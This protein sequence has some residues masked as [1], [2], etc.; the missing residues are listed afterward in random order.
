[1]LSHELLRRQPTNPAQPSYAEPDNNPHIKQRN[2][3]GRQAQQWSQQNK[4]GSAHGQPDTSMP[5][6]DHS[7]DMQAQPQIQSTF[8]NKRKNQ[9]PAAG[10]V[11]AAGAA[12]DPGQAEL[13]QAMTTSS[14]KQAILPQSSGTVP[15]WEQLSA[16][17]HASAGQASQVQTHDLNFTLPYSHIV[18]HQKLHAC[19]PA[20]VVHAASVHAASVHT[21]QRATRA[22][23]SRA[24]TAAMAYLSVLMPGFLIVG[25]PIPHS[26]AAIAAEC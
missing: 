17:A 2:E 23:N 11:H 1:M 25:Q 14:A 15:P 13:V 5:Q 9:L 19:T 24:C 22:C 7:T 20:N 10:S 8:A 3:N 18:Q 4:N 6:P 12:A 26:Q 21:L 16:A